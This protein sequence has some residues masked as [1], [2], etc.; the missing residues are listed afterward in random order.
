[1]ARPQWRVPDVRLTLVGV[2]FVLAWIGIGIRLVDVQAVHADEYAEQGLDQRVKSEDLPAAR[3]T[4]F[5]RDGVELAVTVGSVTIFSDPA[6]VTD[7]QVTARVLSPL[8]GISEPDLVAKLTADT[9]FTY[10][11]R[12][13]ER[14]EADRVRE[15]VEAAGLTGIFFR[16][17]PARIYPAGSLA[18]QLVGFVR[19][20]D[21]VGIEGIEFQY[22]EVL[23]G[24]PGRQIVERDP[25]RNPIPQG[26]Y[27]VEPPVHGADLVL[28]VDREIQFAVEQ[29]LAA[30]VAETG[31]TAGTIVVLDVT[32]GEVLAMA[33]APTFDPNRRSSSDPTSYR[34]RAVAD[35]YE[36]GSTL[37]VVTIA[38]A[39]EEGLIGPA[40]RLTL[41]AKYIIDLD[42][43]PKVYTD[44]GR[45]KEEELTVAEIVARSSNIGTIVIQGLLGNDMHHQ[46]LSSFGLGQQASGQ[47]PGEASGLLRP[48]D[49]WCETT[50]GPS[51]AIGYRVDV[52]VLQMAAV[53][54]TIGNNG[55]WVEPH[56]VKEIIHPD[57]TRQPFEPVQRPVLSQ[58]T[59]RTMQ[60]LLQGVVES[61]RGTGW[62]ASVAGYTVG[63]KTGT[64]EKF[65]PDLGAYSS[66]D[67]VA[68]FIGIAPI[69]SPRIAVA[70]MLDTPAGDDAAGDDLRF[71]GVS[72]AP[73]FAEVVEAA[74]HRL[75]VAPDAG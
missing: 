55:V 39:L 13:M 58:E 9:R 51:T 38:G 18:S 73:V 31:A 41:P 29:A 66:D 22:N 65:L 63:G 5:D 7:A 54:A 53:F 34:N 11:A 23:E 14:D 46:Y 10:L 60:K 47:L 59:A 35:M 17:E 68:S 67:R 61:D 30:V 36:P 32:T 33:S 70:V 56:V 19:S 28:T 62:R 3:G 27:V 15:V 24:E 48:V 45:R 25:Y 52:T 21:L 12:Q 20:D 16:D 42:P 75:G 1:V 8:V 2:V 44:V 37:K 50:C 26:Q 71:G 4:I 57:G 74:L 69:S 40:S 49:E 43:D 64:T 72:A 6:F